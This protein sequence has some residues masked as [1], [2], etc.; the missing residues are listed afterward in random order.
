MVE[1]AARDDTLNKN[2]GAFVNAGEILVGGTD[3][4]SS[5]TMPTVTIDSIEGG[6]LLDWVDISI[7]SPGGIY[8]YEYAYTLNGTQPQWG[9]NVYTSTV[10]EVIIQ[11][12]PS[13]TIKAMV[14]ARLLNMAVTSEKNVVGV[15]GGV[16]IGE[17]AKTKDAFDLAVINTADGK[18]ARFL[19]KVYLPNPAAITKLFTNI[20]ALAVNDSAA[21]VIRI[22]RDDAES[23]SVEITFTTTG[24]AELVI[25][26]ANFSPG[27]VTIDAFDD[28]ET[29]SN[30]AAFTAETFGFTYIEGQ[31]PNT[32]SSQSSSPTI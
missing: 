29:G 7:P 30:Q 4:A 11:A 19:K 9:G 32:G 13:T 2:L 26:G 5:V 15:A 28:D 12:A 10:S 3:S 16:I 17:N 31:V 25:T 20:S 22:Y 1:V 27:W 24:V 8:N 14:R 21:G 23:D 6:V 18:A